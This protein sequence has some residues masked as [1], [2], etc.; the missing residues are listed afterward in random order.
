MSSS[1]A[2]AEEPSEEQEGGLSAVPD[3]DSGELAIEAD[4]Q[5]GMKVGGRKP[6]SAILK[7]KGAK[8]DLGEGQFN[9]GDRITAVTILQVTGDNDQDT[10]NT[11]SGEVKSTSKA[12]NATVCGISRLDDWLRS[13]ID[14]PKLVDSVLKTLEG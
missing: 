10:I 6:D 7:V 11:L 5:I 4:G 14:D 13:Q 1:A 2:A 9:R 12:Q 8:I 3:P